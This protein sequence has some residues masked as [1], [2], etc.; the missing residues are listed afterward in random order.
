MD[1][2]VDKIYVSELMNELKPYEQYKMHFAKYDKENEPLD[3]FMRS[4]D[5]W[6]G[7][8]CWSNGK[9]D[10]NRKFIFSLIYFYP[11][12]DTWLFGGIWEVIKTKYDGPKVEGYDI[13]LCDDY[14]KYIGRLKIS[15]SHRD[16]AVRN[17]ME[18]YFPELVVKEVLPEMYSVLPFP[19]YKKVD[20]PFTALENIIN[21][22]SLEWKN[23]ISLKGIY[24][25]TD[26]ESGM[27]YVGKA[28][29]ENGFWQRWKDYINDGHGGDV[30]L[31]RLI[32]SKGGLNHARKYYKFTL[33][34]IVESNLEKD[35]DDR[36]TYWKNVLMSRMP[37]VGHNKN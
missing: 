25:I 5:E 20:I 27:K 29:G 13:N 35:I 23:A 24:L 3:V 16:R 37:G 31:K 33:L 21:K 32:A 4:F 11:E 10:F 17:R 28:S 19:G 2:K 26:T 1:I 7:W 30:D 9:D 15:Y 12:P 8:N 18:N 22:D 6:K 36:E 34:E 14:K